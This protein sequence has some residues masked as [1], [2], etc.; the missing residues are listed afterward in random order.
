MGCAEDGG[1]LNSMYCRDQI[2]CEFLA[3]GEEQG[4][5]HCAHAS[6]LFLSV[7]KTLP[8]LKSQY[9]AENVF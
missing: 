7:S 9:A 6:M 3:W 4:D 8:C 5:K 2:T 1:N